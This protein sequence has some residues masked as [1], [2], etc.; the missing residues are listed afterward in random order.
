MTH[1]DLS[2]QAGRG[3]WIFGFGS[4]RRSG[5]PQEIGVSVQSS[6]QEVRLRRAYDSE[7]FA[8]ASAG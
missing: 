2:G 6:C 7:L 8:L 4:R 1:Q 5:P 3:I